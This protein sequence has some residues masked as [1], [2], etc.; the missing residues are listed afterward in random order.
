MSYVLSSDALLP[1][2]YTTAGRQVVATFPTYIEAQRAVDHLADASFP[3]GE[4]DIVGRDVS[5]VEHVTGRTTTASATAAGAGTG[6][7][8]GLFIGLLVGLFTP[9]PA[10]LGLILG[11][12]LIGAVW[13]TVFGLVA[14]W[15]TGGRHDF[16]SVRGLVAARYEV[17]VTDIHSE[18]AR[19]LLASVR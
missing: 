15:A 14:H 9:G 16:A 17:T 1:D 4:T 5:L 6:A 2:G 7:W 19:Q 8:F 13:G 11:G 18:R 12:L 10:W 3:I